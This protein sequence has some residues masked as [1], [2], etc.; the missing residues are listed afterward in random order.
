MPP[1]SPIEFKALLW[2]VATL[3]SIIAFVG[4]VF[5]N[6][7]IKLVKDVGEI[8]TELGIANE[9]HDGLERRVS[10]VEKKVLGI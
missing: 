4:V 2:F 8:K 7:F 10:V 9:K 5:V 3:L 1:V 6:Y